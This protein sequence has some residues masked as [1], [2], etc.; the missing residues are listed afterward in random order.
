MVYRARMPEGGEIIKFENGYYLFDY[1]RPGS[2]VDEAGIKQGDTLI[3]MNS[4][5]IEEWE[6]LNYRPKPGDTIINGVLRNNHAVGFPVIVRSVLSTA[7]GLFWFMYIIMIIFST[8]SL[9]LLYKKPSDKAVWLIFI[10]LQFFM[11]TLNAQHLPTY[12]EPLAVIAEFIF[13]ILGCFGGSVLIHFHLLFPRPAKIIRKYRR[14]P[15]LLYV[16][17]ALLAIGFSSSYIYNKLIEGPSFN[18]AFDV[19]NRVTLWWLT[20]SFLLALATAIYQF[21]SIKDTLS[22][23]QLRIVITGAFFSC[24]TPISITLFYNQINELVGK[25]PYMFALFQ[26]IGGLIMICCI[27]I[28]IFRYRL[29]NIE[30]FIRKALLYLG[31]TLVI[32]LSYLLLLYIVDLLTISETKIT[33]FVILAVS[34]I[35]FLALRDWIQR[36]IDRV[37]HREPYDSATV[38][39]DFE[40]KLAGI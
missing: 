7:F 23:N 11:V 37:F 39:S 18:S 35:I 2:P 21:F 26:G 40:E 5:P 31:A 33:R 6:A 29:W 9:Y 17:G 14:L 19:F 1:V 15:I 10:Y 32:I 8:G 28:A 13:L 20:V 27:L 4:M 25:F 30:V 34:V 12:K 22:R 16:I 38:V 3:S 36:L 24:I